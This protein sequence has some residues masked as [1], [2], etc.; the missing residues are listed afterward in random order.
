VKCPETGENCHRTL[1]YAQQKCK[2]HENFKIR[3]DAVDAD[4]IESELR[5]VDEAIEKFVKP[6]AG[7][8]IDYY[9][10]MTYSD[11][12]RINKHLS[13]YRE[14]IK[15]KSHENN[16]LS[17]PLIICAGVKKATRLEQ[18]AISR[19]VLSD[20]KSVRSKLFNACKF[21]QINIKFHFSYNFLYFLAGGGD[22]IDLKI[23][24]HPKT[25]YTLYLRYDKTGL[26][27]F[28]SMNR[29]KD[30][31]LSSDQLERVFIGIFEMRNLSFSIDSGYGELKFLCDEIKFKIS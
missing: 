26:I 6:I 8:G 24:Q 12:L 4:D 21:M 25:E 3:K 28:P 30:G 19:C 2:H 5:E 13:E 23:Y 20:D 10:G 7:K 18:M 22:L 11:K 17:I 31:N 27:E 14:L 29:F 15:A 9:F 16:I 1:G